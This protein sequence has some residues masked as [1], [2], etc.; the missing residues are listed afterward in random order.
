[1]ADSRVHNEFKLTTAED[2]ERVGPGDDVTL[3]CHL[4]PKTS[5]V[6]MTIRWFKGTEC[7]YLYKNGQVTESIGYE[8]RVSL[9]TQELETG[10]VSLRLRDF[11]RSDDGWYI[12]QVIH[13]DQKEEAA[14]GLE[15]ASGSRLDFVEHSKGDDRGVLERMEELFGEGCWEHTVILFTHADDLKEQSIEEFLQALSQGPP[16]ACREMWQ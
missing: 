7:I 1:M 13:G 9:I 11:R 12:C 14:V 2:S 4:F 3:S 8:G 10:N 5:A 15:V 6:V 16:A